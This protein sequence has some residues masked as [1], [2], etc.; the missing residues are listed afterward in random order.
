[1]QDCLLAGDVGFEG[2]DRRH[3]VFGLAY[4]F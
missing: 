2:T 1:L 4:A 3:A